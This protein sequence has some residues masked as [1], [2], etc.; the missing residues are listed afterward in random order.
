MNRLLVYLSAKAT[1]NVAA[2][3][4]A[5]GLCVLGAGLAT[6]RADAVPRPRLTAAATAAVRATRAS[7][8]HDYRTLVDAK[9][10][11]RL[12]PDQADA[13][14]RTEQ[15]TDEI[16]GAAPAVYGATYRVT[17]DQVTD[18]THLVWVQVETPAGEIATYEWHV[19]LV[20]GRWATLDLDVNPGGAAVPTS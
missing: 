10:A 5:V 12:T 6:G 9:F 8:E 3:G 1:R 14:V 2:G 18:A 13:A 11:G 16:A 4:L 7:L 17:L 20:G 15:A 19:V